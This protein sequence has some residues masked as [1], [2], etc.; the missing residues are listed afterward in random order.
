MSRF[1]Y[2]AVTDRLV[3]KY[4]FQ[5]VSFKLHAQCNSLSLRSLFFSV[6]LCKLESFVDLFQ[7]E[8]I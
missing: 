3:S 8:V 2:L 7:W 4:S 5:R 6:P 1:F